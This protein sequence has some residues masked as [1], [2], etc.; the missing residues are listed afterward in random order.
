MSVRAS[1]R[2]GLRPLYKNSAL[3][4][5]TLRK[6][7]EGVDILRH[8]AA[9]VF[10]KV[11]QPEP[12]NLFITLTAHC[13]LRCKGCHYGRDFMP[14]STLDLQ[15]VKDLVTD[16]K[17]LGFERV[18]LYGG[19]PL[20]HK[21]LP[22][23]VEHTAKAGLGMWMTTNGV[24]LKRK[25]DD[26]YDA[27][28]RKVSIGFYGIR[29]DYN[30]YVQRDDQ[31]DKVEE[32]I[33]YVRE[34]YGS[35]IQMYLDWLLMRPTCSMKSLHATWEFA[36]R[37]NL[38]IYVNLLHYSLPYFVKPDEEVEIQFSEKDHD[39]IREVAAELLRMKK[40]RPDLLHNSEHGLRSIPDWLIKGQEMKVPCTEYRLIWIGA[41]G[42]VQMCYVTF[43]LGNLNEKRLSEMLFTPKHK[44]AAQDAFALNCPNC[45]CSYDSRVLRHGPTRALY[46]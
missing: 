45:H 33:A 43:K 29:E 40:E 12:R 6:A 30:G 23:I 42:T 41:D 14:G 27:G 3:V 34:R 39:T 1:L 35:K 24:L 11:I 17:E 18:R 7:D 16:A 38:G 21:D 20:L 26:L 22:E 4:N 25:I 13:N 36:L 37:Y 9:R 8:S 19:E 10:P 28:L 2:E 32:S 5:R 44:Q 46:S 15:V 31:F